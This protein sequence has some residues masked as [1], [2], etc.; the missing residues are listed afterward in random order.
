MPRNCTKKTKGPQTR[1]D[2]GFQ[3]GYLGRAFR[4]Y[5]PKKERR[6]QPPSSSNNGTDLYYCPD[7]NKGYQSGVKE[8]KRTGKVNRNLKGLVFVITG[9]FVT[10]LL[11]SLL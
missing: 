10:A 3:D 8:R 6:K 2:Q 7:Y 9:L 1:R 11:I 5:S 4:Y